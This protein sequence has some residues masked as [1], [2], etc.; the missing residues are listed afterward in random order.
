MTAGRPCILHRACSD[1]N[2]LKFSKSFANTSQIYRKIDRHGCLNVD[3]GNQPEK[4]PVSPPLCW[5][6]LDSENNLVEIG[7]DR[8]TGMLAS[9]S[10]PLYNGTL[11]PL[12]EIQQHNNDILGIP[13]F[14]TDLW[15]PGTHTYDIA[16]DLYTVQGRCN[17]ELGQER[18]RIVLFLDT[19]SYCVVSG[20]EIICEFNHLDELCA[21]SILGLHS[22]EIETITSCFANKK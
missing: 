15:D 17:V 7:I 18:V 2:K 14:N 21:V 5:R 22:T 12:N 20:G 19:I 13:G 1:M 3:I 16:A 4:T 6:L 11:Y 10:M 9:I 8:D